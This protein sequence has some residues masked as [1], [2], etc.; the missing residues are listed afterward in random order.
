MEEF[1]HCIHKIFP[2]VIDTKVM[3]ALMT[4]GDA[5]D[6]NLE[7]LFKHYKLQDCPHGRSIPGWG[8]N[9]Y[10]RSFGYKKQVAHEAGFDSTYSGSSSRCY[11]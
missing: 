5:V 11:Y 9:V 2:R 10:N 8:F 6:E 7:G 4:D 3:T 1:R